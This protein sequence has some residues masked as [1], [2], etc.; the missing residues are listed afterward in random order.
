M[1]KCHFK[2]RCHLEF[3]PVKYKQKEHLDKKALKTRHADIKKLYINS[4]SE[5]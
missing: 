4:T 2:C 5:H 3:K 1:R